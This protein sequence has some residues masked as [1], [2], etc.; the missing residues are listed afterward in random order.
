M[1]LLKI[2][3]KSISR[4]LQVPRHNVIDGYDGSGSKLRFAG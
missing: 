4:F 2:T 1:Q 3:E